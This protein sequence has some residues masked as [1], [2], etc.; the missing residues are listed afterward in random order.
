MMYFICT[1]CDYCEKDRKNDDGQVRCTR[2]SKF[3]N[4]DDMECKDFHREVS[5]VEELRKLISDAELRR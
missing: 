1:D 3:V 2:F 5:S 4:P